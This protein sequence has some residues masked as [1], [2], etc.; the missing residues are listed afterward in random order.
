MALPSFLQ[1]VFSGWTLEFYSRLLI[2]APQSFLKIYF[3]CVSC[4]H[5]SVDVQMWRAKEGAESLEARVIGIC[6]TVF[7]VR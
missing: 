7:I 6:E 5:V 3:I 2:P 4:V 1:F